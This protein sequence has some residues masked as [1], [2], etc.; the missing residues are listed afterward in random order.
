MSLTLAQGPST[1]RQLS[2]EDEEEQLELSSE[3][4]DTATRR[5]RYGSGKKGNGVG[6]REANSTPGRVSPGEVAGGP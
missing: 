2:E 1:G 5:S 6:G 3:G 4:W